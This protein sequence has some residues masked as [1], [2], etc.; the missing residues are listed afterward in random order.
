MNYPPAVSDFQS[1]FNRD[2][3]Y[4]TGLQAIQTN[5]VQRALNEA[6]SIFNPGLWVSTTEMSTAYLYLA[7][8]L[9]VRNLQVVGGPSP[10]N[11]G[12]GV[13][14]KG[15]GA[16]ESKGAGAVNVSYAVPDFVRQ[17][18]ILSQFMQTDYGQRY[19]QMLTPRLVGNVG[20]VPSRN[21][22][23]SLY[24]PLP[25]TLQ[26]A[27]LTLPGG[28]HAVAYLQSVTVTGGVS[29]VTFIVS[30]G[31]LPAGITLASSNSAGVLSGTPTTA[32][33]YYFGI[34]A[35]DSQGNTAT[36]NYQLVI[37]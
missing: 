21:Y 28:T 27:T 29:P 22:P 12:I 14:S 2:F 30:Q 26:I 20:S 10:T 24:A 1:Y 34:T 9:M 5:D 32:G 37:A 16:T 23:G 15:A 8:H 3:I 35:T 6:S 11:R 19:L 4:G 31:T 7:A 25:A 13:Q 36:Q 18:P 17:S 33:T